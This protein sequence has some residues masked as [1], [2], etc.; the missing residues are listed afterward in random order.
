[1]GQESTIE[2]NAL[3]LLTNIRLGWK[4]LPATN[5]LTYQEHFFVFFSKHLTVPFHDITKFIVTVIMF[6]QKTRYRM[7]TYSQLQFKGYDKLKYYNF[8][9]STSSNFISQHTKKF[10][11][12]CFVTISTL[13]TF[14]YYR[15]I[16]FYNDEPWGQCYKTFC[17]LKLRIFIVSQ[18]VCHW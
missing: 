12:Q 8:Q 15:R 10:S 11:P 16:K 18:S 13:Q 14:V 7:H 5:T 4:G 1:M 2:W 6:N 17:V 3:A 9:S